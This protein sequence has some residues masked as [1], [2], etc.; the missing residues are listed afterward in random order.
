MLSAIHFYSPG[1]KIYLYIEKYLL[2]GQKEK[3]KGWFK[4]N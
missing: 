4:I 1:V 2:Q 3:K